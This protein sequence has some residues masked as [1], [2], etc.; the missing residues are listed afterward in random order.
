MVQGKGFKEKG[1]SKKAKVNP[2]KTVFTILSLV[3]VSSVLAT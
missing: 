3:L 1:K 2:G